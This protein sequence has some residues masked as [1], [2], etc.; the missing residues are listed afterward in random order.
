VPRRDQ[1]NCSNLTLRIPVIPP[2]GRYRAGTSGW[3][4]RLSDA[5]ENA[6][7]VSERS[8]RDIGID[9]DR[10]VFAWNTRM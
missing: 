7:A 6:V 5:L 2:A 1:G 9:D 8:L 4:R 10:I 3:A